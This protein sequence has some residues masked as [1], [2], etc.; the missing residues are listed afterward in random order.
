MIQYVKLNIPSIDDL[1]NEVAMESTV[2]LTKKG[3]FN[4]KK[5][6]NKK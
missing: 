6:I 2:E 3:Y 5:F 1:D 4:I